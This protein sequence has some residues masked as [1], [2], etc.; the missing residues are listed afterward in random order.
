MADIT[1]A[2]PSDVIV[3]LAKSASS[4]GTDVTVEYTVRSS[5]SDSYYLV[6]SLL[7]SVTSGLMTELLVADGY[8]GIEASVLP[9]IVILT[10]SPTP[11]PTPLATTAFSAGQYS[12]IAVTQV[13]PCHPSFFRCLIF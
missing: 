11:S 13:S 1:G 12:S 2:L 7:D 4:S 9:E 8:A 5:S 6:S 10:E 3:T